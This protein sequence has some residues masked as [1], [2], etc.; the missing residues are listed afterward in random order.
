MV[1][2]SSSFD[3]CKQPISTVNPTIILPKLVSELFLKLEDKD[4]LIVVMWISLFQNLGFIWEE[5]AN[6]GKNFFCLVEEG[7]NGS[8][9]ISFV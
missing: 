9:H 3:Y 4:E 6:S 8:T 7:E 5:R 1:E 2:L